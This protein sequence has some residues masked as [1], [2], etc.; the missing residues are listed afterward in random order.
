[1]AASISSTRHAAGV[2]GQV[3]RRAQVGRP[4]ASI[5][6]LKMLSPLPA[7]STQPSVQG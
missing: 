1:M 4:M 2:V 3:G 6:R 7:T 5:N